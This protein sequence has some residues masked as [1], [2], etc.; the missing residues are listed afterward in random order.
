MLD[1][2]TIHSITPHRIG[3]NR[4]YEISMNEVSVFHCCSRPTRDEGGGFFTSDLNVDVAYPARSWS[5]HLGN[6]IRVVGV[7]RWADNQRSRRECRRC[8]Q[9]PL[10][11]QRRMWLCQ[12]ICPIRWS[13]SIQ[14][15]SVLDWTC[16]V[17]SGHHPPPFIEGRGFAW[18]EL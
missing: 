7:F 18:V 11:L 13:Y 15:D 5:D 4:L 2:G 12:R 17:R 1:E 14:P 6:G 3:L 8:H 16:T 10:F 9:L